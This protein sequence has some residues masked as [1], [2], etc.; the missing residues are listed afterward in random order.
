MNRCVVVTMVAIVFLLTAAEAIA[1]DVSV[2]EWTK[3]G[4]DR[5]LTT[6]AKMTKGA[7]VRIKVVECPGG[8]VNGIVIWNTIGNRQVGPIKR[9]NEI[10]PGQILKFTLP[11]DQVISLTTLPVDYAIIAGLDRMGTF[12]RITLERGGMKWV[13]DV[14]VVSPF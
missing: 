10:T 6:T 13:L 14:K 5:I 2:A 9:W 12:H 4:G 3:M 7:E 8:N 1:Q 11:D